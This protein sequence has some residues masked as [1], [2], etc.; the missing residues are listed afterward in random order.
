MGALRG[1]DARVYLNTSVYATP[2]WVEWTC[3]RDTTLNIEYEEADATCRGSGGWR[4]S[5]ITLASLEVSGTALKEK[6]DA[7]FLLVETAAQAKTVMDLLVL[8][9]PRLSTDSDG[10]RLQAQVFSWTENQPMEDVVTIDFSIK[11]A[12]DTN[13]PAAVSGPQASTGDT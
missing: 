8:D 6:S 11:P 2:T 12:R 3:V 10:Y 4:Q 9:G 1:I 13:P 7:T 5:A